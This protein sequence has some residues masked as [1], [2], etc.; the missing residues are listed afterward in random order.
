MREIYRI[1]RNDLP[2]YLKDFVYDDKESEWDDAFLAVWIASCESH[3]MVE[4][5]KGNT[6]ILGWKDDH[7]KLLEFFAPET[8]KRIVAYAFERLKLENEQN[9]AAERSAYIDAK[10]DDEFLEQRRQA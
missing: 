9:A 8:L 3:W 1:E 5:I 4:L 2:E 10:K 7:P 6:I